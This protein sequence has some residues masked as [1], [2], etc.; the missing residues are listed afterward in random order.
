LVTRHGPARFPDYSATK[1]AQSDRRQGEKISTSAKRMTSGD[2]IKIGTTNV[3]IQGN[4][5]GLMIFGKSAKIDEE[6]PQEQPVKLQPKVLHAPMVPIGINTFSKAQIT[7]AKGKREQ[8]K[9][10]RKNI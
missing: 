9:G 10:G 8:I 1:T 4:N 3:V 5:E 7:A 2:I 6:N